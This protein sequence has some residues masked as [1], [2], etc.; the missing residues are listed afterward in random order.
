MGVSLIAQVYC[1][2]LCNRVGIYEPLALLTLPYMMTAYVYR[3]DIP[4]TTTASFHHLYHRLEPLVDPPHLAL[5][6]PAEHLGFITG[7]E[8][9]EFLELPADA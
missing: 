8:H 7:L 5:I 9:T 6:V 3:S 1:Y 2:W 4:A